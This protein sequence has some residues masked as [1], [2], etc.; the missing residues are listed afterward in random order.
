M[1]KRGVNR[2]GPALTA[3]LLGLIAGCGGG[4][5]SGTMP[6][7]ASSPPVASAPVAQFAVG[8]TITG[9]EQGASV[10]LTN[11]SEKMTVAANGSF[12]FPTRLASGSGFSIAASAPGGY[13]CRVSDGTGTLGSADSTKTVVACAPVLLAGA[14]SALQNPLAVAA[15]RSGNLYVVDGAT[16]SVVKFSPAGAMT[17]LAGGSDKPGWV[18]GP[19]AQARFRFGDAGIAV[20]EDG[21]VLVADACNGAIRQI[22]SDG[23]VSTLAG[24]GTPACDMV[25][26]E[27]STDPLPDGAGS[28]AA[29]A[30]PHKII[31][32]GGK[33]VIVIES[34][35]SAPM[36]RVSSTGTVSSETPNAGLSAYR[37]GEFTTGARA[38]D[39]TLYLA[40]SRHIYR[41][42]AGYLMDV[43][44]WVGGPASAD[45]TGAASRFQSIRD[46]V[47]ASSGDL[48]VADG[49]QIR[50][51]TP[52][53][54]VTTL[55][56]DGRGD[57][58]IDGPG[59][60]ARFTSASSITVAEN[61]LVVLDGS[62]GIL[63]HVG[64]DGM[65]KTLAGTVQTR[66]SLDGI[67]NA[68]RLNNVNSLA[69][70]ADG[71]LYFADSG[72]HLLRKAT[73]DGAVTTF[74]GKAG[75]S[76]VADGP[77]ATATFT[78]PRTVAAGRD[79]S[80]W[81]AQA[82]GLRRIFNGAVT[83][84]DPTLS[85]RGLAI[86]PDGNAI[87]A[88][89][90]PI[91]E[92]LRVTPDGRRSVLLSREKIGTVVGIVDSQRYAFTPESVAVD[93]AGNIYV[94][95]PGT[96]AVYKLGRSG[97]VNLFAG[98]PLKERGDMDGPPRTATLGFHDLSYMTIDDKG[99]LY[100]SGQGGV[101]MV[102]AAGVVSSPSYA[103]GKTP[104]SAVTYAKGKLY[105]MTR[106]AL[107]QTWLP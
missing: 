95:D 29:F 25:Q 93:A 106:F 9:L 28:A 43:A 74:A 90:Y 100:L 96:V 51:V 97:E 71:N 77:L 68:A 89:G 34:L 59:L 88:A 17:V 86:D 32:D 44:G 75:V 69:A 57:E 66:G 76:G 103:W 52:A 73:P 60:A 104:I 10:T 79:G 50:K 101:R 61:G 54:V 42:V 67:G 48:Y 5:S 30:L 56:G 81:V 18:D 26:P 91:N 83:T 24:R 55:A 11:G 21:T 1:L 33:N 14:P 38:P 98:T 63:R 36:R 20:D 37:G 105:G 45:G 12:A 35:G 84:V 31:R 22:A 72:K 85:V 16:Y 94:A 39:G 64:F 40:D 27:G 15:D 70:D 65:V 4:G 92:V 2:F 3:V 82:A 7:P 47:V 87:V 107:L 62:S 6:A 8:G 49:V 58:A 46:M 13:S 23:I 41:Y 19:G 102:S 80:L 53:G 78:T 99:N